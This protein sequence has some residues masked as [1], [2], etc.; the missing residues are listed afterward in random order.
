MLTILSIVVITILKFRHA[1]PGI[2]DTDII[3][4]TKRVNEV[5]VLIFPFQKTAKNHQP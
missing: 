4:I 5:S 1:M 3:P 2:K